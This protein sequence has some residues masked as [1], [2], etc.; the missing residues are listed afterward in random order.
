MWY[1]ISKHLPAMGV[2]WQSH[3]HTEAVRLPMWAVVGRK[4]Q[5][6]SGVVG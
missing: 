2:E 1:M 6:A 3:A 4:P 5:A